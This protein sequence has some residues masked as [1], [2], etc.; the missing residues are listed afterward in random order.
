MLQSP[1]SGPPLNAAAL[2]TTPSTCEGLQE[3]SQIQTVT[4]ISPLSL[5]HH[6]QQTSPGADLSERAKSTGL[7]YTA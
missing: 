7:G 5:S 4:G 1:S 2:G 3:A 6:S